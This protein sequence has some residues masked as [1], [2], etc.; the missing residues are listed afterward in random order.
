VRLYPAPGQVLMRYTVLSAAVQQNGGIPHELEGMAAAQPP[1]PV[2][3]RFAPAQSEPHTA[4]SL[5]RADRASQLHSASHLVLVC[6]CAG[7]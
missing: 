5:G 7:R 3:L 6:G 2:R 4:G 1:P